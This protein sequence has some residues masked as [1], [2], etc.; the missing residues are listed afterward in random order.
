MGCC[1][2]IG[3]FHVKQANLARSSLE[4]C[5]FSGGWQRPVRIPVRWPKSFAVVPFETLIVPMRRSPRITP[6]GGL[7]DSHLQLSG[8]G[9]VGP[10]SIY[11]QFAKPGLPRALKLATFVG[12]ALCL[13]ALRKTVAWTSIINGCWLFASPISWPPTRAGETAAATQF[14]MGSMSRRL[15]LGQWSRN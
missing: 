12:V 2:R 8:H 1:Y 14:S 5:P 11:A 6:F 7:A 3:R 10:S 15:R 4:A 13:W 9:V